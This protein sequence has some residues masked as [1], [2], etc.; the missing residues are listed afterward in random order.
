MPIVTPV[1]EKLFC[2]MHD[3]N[4]SD[5]FITAEAPIHIKINGSVA[6]INQQVMKPEQVRRI[7]EEAAHP[8]V[9]VVDTMDGAAAK[10]AELAAN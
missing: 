1:L 10:A 3:R 7:L 4:A 6:P 5:I 8:L 2:A 9:T